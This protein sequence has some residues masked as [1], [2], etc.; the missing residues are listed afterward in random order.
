MSIDPKNLEIL[1]TFADS[2]KQYCEFVESC[3]NGRPDPFYSRI[4]AILSALQMNI[5]P[6]GS[7]MAV[8]DE[9][10][11]GPLRM[12]TVERQE[13]SRMIAETVAAES[14]ALPE[15]HQDSEEDMT[16][17]VML[18]DDLAG[19]YGDL[20]D[21]LVLWNSGFPE[22]QVEAAWQ[23]RWG[24]QI[25]WGRHLLRAMMTVHEIRYQLLAM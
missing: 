24:Y 14:K 7:E 6:V 19:V 9:S 20:H 22:S 3:R 12:S 17:A 8:A 1:A 13:M 16:R 10:H 15:H 5:L 4:E 23:W 18:F 11:F 25:H 21:G 2:A